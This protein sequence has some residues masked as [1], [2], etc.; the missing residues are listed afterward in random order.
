MYVLEH[1][2]QLI[3]YR[4]IKS[5]RKSVAIIVF[6]TKEVIVRAP[7]Q[8][9]SD[10]IKNIVRSKG[11]W[12]IKKRNEMPEIVIPKKRD[13]T[14]G[15]KILYR[16]KEY[17]IKVINTVGISQSTILLKEKEII[18]VKK[19]KEKKK[20][21]EL[22]LEWYKGEAKSLVKERI[23]FYM[24]QIKKPIGDIRIKSQKKRWGSCSSKGNLN[25]NWKIVMM[26]DEMFDYIIVHEL[27]HLKHLNHSKLFW[28]SVEKILP[29]YKIREKWIKEN[30]LQLDFKGGIL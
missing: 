4:V 24:P 26:P 23:E 3:N 12:I 6:P 15:D 19:T 18:I 16:G 9:S 14:E 28:E 2:N 8:I 13:Y 22:L 30:T 7:N 11:D 5:N 29:D 1:N 17:T 10:K 21:Q 20:I 27:C 25:F